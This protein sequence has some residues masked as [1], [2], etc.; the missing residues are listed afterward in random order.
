MNTWATEHMTYVCI[1]RTSLNEGFYTENSITVQ[2]NS[3]I[4]LIIHVTQHLMEHKV[5]YFLYKYNNSDLFYAY[6]PNLMQT[7]K[8]SERHCQIQ[9]QKLLLSKH[10][11]KNI[12]LIDVLCRS[13]ELQEQV[14]GNF[15]LKLFWKPE[16]IQKL[17]P[18]NAQ[19]INR[20]FT[21]SYTIAK[22]GKLLSTSSNIR[23][24]TEYTHFEYL[25]YK[26]DGVNDFREKHFKALVIQKTPCALTFSEL[27]NLS[28]L[29]N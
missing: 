8:L 19:H 25:T 3:N 10:L 6:F 2:P 12:S 4:P 29:S 7:C 13:Y 5:E 22:D 14:D 15:K 17:L 24:R 26:Q 1:A 28:L 9:L 21:T 18:I 23:Y 11:N 27:Y 20:K 16:A